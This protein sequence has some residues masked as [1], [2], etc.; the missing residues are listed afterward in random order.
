MA[1]AA[2]ERLL[3]QRKARKRKA[4]WPQKIKNLRTRCEEEIAD[5]QRKSR[6]HIEAFDEEL[7][8]A[9]S[10]IFMLEHHGPS[11]VEIVDVKTRGFFRRLWWALR[12]V[13]GKTLE[14]ERTRS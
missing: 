11:V 9:R 13:F 4:R 10:R 6:E 2:T 12:F 14:Y 5:A 1:S 8:Q 7:R 3:S